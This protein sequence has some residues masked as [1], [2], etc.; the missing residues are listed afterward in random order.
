MRNRRMP[1]WVSG[2]HV[3]DGREQSQARRS[4]RGPSLERHR[5]PV[6]AP[7]DHRVG[8]ARGLHERRDALGVVLTVGVEHQDGLRPLTLAQQC[9]YPGR[10]GAALAAV[11]TEREHID[12][13]VLR[14][15]RERAGDLGRRPVVHQNEPVDVAQRRAGDLGGPARGEHG[16]DRG[17]RGRPRPQ[18]Q[19]AGAPALGDDQGDQRDQR[20]GAQPKD[21]PVAAGELDGDAGDRQRECGGHARGRRRRRR[22]SCPPPP[23]ARS[24]RSRRSRARSGGR[25]RSRRWRAGGRPRRA[26]R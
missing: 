16:H 20:G 4:V 19:G 24:A 22:C 1:F 18:R 12:A 14:Q 5:A 7:P 26:W 2:I 6:A 3:R 17:D 21:G 23:R 13:L 25:R 8:R 9:P 10:Y 11:V 15:G